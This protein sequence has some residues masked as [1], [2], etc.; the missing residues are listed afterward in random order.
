MKICLQG[1][2]AIRHRSIIE[3]NKKKMQKCDSL[4]LE[5]NSL[6]KASIKDSSSIKSSGSNSI[7]FSASGNISLSN[8]GGISSPIHSNQVEITEEEMNQIDSIINSLLSGSE[9]EYIDPLSIPKLEA[10]LKFRK[11]KAIEDSDYQ[12]AKILEK[13]IRS[14]SKY[15]QKTKT[16]TLSPSKQKEFI[17]EL[18]NK[19]QILNAQL[20][21]L[22][23]NFSEEKERI[24]T[25]RE[26]SL[27]SLYAQNEKEINELLEEKSDIMMGVGFKQ[28]KQLNELRHQEK[29]FANMSLFD[30]A[31]EMKK[32][33]E[34]LEMQER[35]EFDRKSSRK[36]DI[37]EK[38]QRQKQ[39]SKIKATEEYWDNL[40]EKTEIKFEN[41]IK[42]TQ[43]EIDKIKAKIEEISG[44]KFVNENNND[45]YS[46]FSGLNFSFNDNT[47]TN[48][49]NNSNFDDDDKNNGLGPNKNSNFESENTSNLNKN[50][51]RFEE[52]EDEA[53][54]DNI[55]SD[56][57]NKD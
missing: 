9:I 45:T 24:N 18:E 36:F 46:E 3:N 33:A 56:D 19:L 25:D 17:S 4:I 53:F 21:Q 20:K 42:S 39:K 22:I 50:D 29:V 5:L 8:S 11:S 13:N 54:D 15:R 31:S 7:N 2:Q 40:L 6:E 43:N 37:K 47:N 1:L 14:L 41:R 49:D 48:S 55:K 16:K 27:N 35:R 30:E 57:D 32:K 28:S 51:S 52:D 12:S 26:E 23:N 38:D 10:V 44:K 34:D